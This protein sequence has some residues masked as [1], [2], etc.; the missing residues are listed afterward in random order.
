MKKYRLDELIRLILTTSY[1]N[2]HIAR[3]LII[4]ANTVKKRRDDLKQTSYDWP[5]FRALPEDKLIEFFKQNKNEIGTY[6]CPD[7]HYT[8]K[9]LQA[10]HQ[11]LM[12]AWHEYRA[13]KTNMGHT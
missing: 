4:S 7:W 2:R 8:T 12:Q 1:S 3:L 10:R 9:L 13:I 11:T 6:R 5:Y